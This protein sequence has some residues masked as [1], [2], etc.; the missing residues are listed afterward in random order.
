M[1]NESSQLLERIAALEQRLALTEDREA[2]RRLQYIYGYY[3]DNRM[4]DEVADLFADE[5]ASI[6]IGRRGVYHDKARIRRF[7]NEVLGQG[8]WGL[9]KDEFINHIQLQMVITVAPDGRQAWARARGVVQ[10]NSPAQATNTTM[11]WAEGSYE[12]TYVKEAGVW[13]IKSLWWIPTFYV[14]M[15]G[16]N[17]ALFKSGPA[18]E[19]FPPDS[20]SHPPDDALGRAFPEWHYR[21]P[22]TGEKVVTPPTSDRKKTEQNE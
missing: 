8:R 19:S 22:M 14:Q 7:L 17:T 4:W 5:G 15:P 18:S 9:E 6:E 21:H 13:K 3:L 12:N 10:G 1:N 20:P 11:L 2:I 16:F